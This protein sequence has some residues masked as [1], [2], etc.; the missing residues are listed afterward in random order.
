MLGAG[1][2]PGSNLQSAELS[3]VSG[4][5]K[6]GVKIDRYDHNLEFSKT[7]FRDINGNKRNWVD[8]AFGLQGDWDYKNLLISAKFQT[9]KSLNYNWLLKDYTAN[10]YYIPH[11]TVYN[12]RGELGLTYR[13]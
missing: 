6:I 11:N 13:F 9:V 2:G 1:I 7:E 8:I 10:S 3:W 4:L 12:L 5:K